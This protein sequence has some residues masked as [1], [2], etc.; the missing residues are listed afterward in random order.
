MKMPKGSAPYRSA[1]WEHAEEIRALRLKRQSWRAI[2]RQ[3]EE[4]H[5]LKMAPNTITRWFERGAAKRWRVPMGFEEATPKRKFPMAS[6]SVSDPFSVEVGAIQSPW[7]PKG[8]SSPLCA[9][10]G[11]PEGEALG[12]NA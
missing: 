6:S 2:A 5:G 4:Q 1:L 12:K 9:M 11:K 8:R 3:L 7:T 10:A